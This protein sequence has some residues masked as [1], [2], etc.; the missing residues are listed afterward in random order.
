M[1]KP[2]NWEEELRDMLE[3]YNIRRD[4]PIVLNKNSGWHSGGKTD[5]EL[6]VDFVNGVLAQELIKELEKMRMEWE[7]GYKSKRHA[8]LV[9][10]RNQVIAE[11]NQKLEKRI[12][13]IKKGGE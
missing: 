2:K 4:F 11:L 5:L 7:D 10:E 9:N 13:E 6:F 8:D 3:V 1:R 12:K